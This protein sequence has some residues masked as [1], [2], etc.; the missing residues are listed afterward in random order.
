MI[1]LWLECSRAYALPI[2]VLSWLVIFCWGLKHGG[3]PVNGLI[4]LVGIACAH[5]ATNLFDDYFDYKVLCKDE[6]FLNSAQSCKCRLIT[7]GVVSHKSYLVEAF[8]LSAVACL[9]G[10]VLFVL[11]GPAVIWLAIIG[12]LIVLGYS[13]FSRIGCGEIAVAIAYGPLLYEGVYYCMT[14]T[15]KPTHFPFC[16]ERVRGNIFLYLVKS[17]IYDPN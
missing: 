7:D 12:A 3:N 10:A 13:K 14:K 15:C 5:L 9:S 16:D 8:V 17:G 6:K 2:T 11:A 1:K 4:A